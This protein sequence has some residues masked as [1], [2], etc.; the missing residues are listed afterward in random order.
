M[1]RLLLRRLAVLGSLHHQLPDDKN[2][3]PLLSELQLAVQQ[4]VQRDAVQHRP[5][6]SPAVHQLRAV[7][8][9]DYR[10]L[11][12]RQLRVGWRQVHSPVR[13]R[14]QTRIV[15]IA[16][17]AAPGERQLLPHELHTIHRWPQLRYDW[18]LRLGRCVLPAALLRPL[19]EPRGVRTERRLLC[20]HCQRFR[21]LQA[22]QLRAADLCFN[23]RGFVRGDRQLRSVA[24]HL[25]HIA[26]R[27]NVSAR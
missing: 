15:R 23:T 6:R 8:R 4:R 5:I 3:V 22:N 2:G 1:E 21:I 16:L 20:R 13:G 10:V 18:R 17:P 9:V 24:D 19:A 12:S 25:L 26:A 14:I 11:S 27:W 7:L